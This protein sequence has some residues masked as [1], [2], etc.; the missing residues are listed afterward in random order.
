[1]KKRCNPSLKGIAQHLRKSMTKEEKKL[2]YNFLKR[3]PITVNRQKVIG[4]YI[5]DF[6]IAEKQIAI[7]IDGAQH[8][9]PENKAADEQRDAELNAAGILVLRYSNM[10]INQE[11]E[12]VCA[13]ISQHIGASLAEESI[14]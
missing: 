5:V 8:A 7:E 3:L 12:G 4:N 11:F 14:Q 13:N 9:M 2:W 1:M 10:E 6:F